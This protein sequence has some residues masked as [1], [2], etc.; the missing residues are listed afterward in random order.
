MLLNYSVYSQS[1]KTAI[2]KIRT[3]D[4]GKLRKLWNGIKSGNTPG[5]ASGKALEYLF[6]RAFDLEK[7]EVVYPYCNNLLHSQEQFDGFIF[8][9][10]LGSGFIVEC[11][12]WKSPVAFDELSKLHGRL[13]YR[14]PSTYG[15]F[16][17]KSGFTLSAMELMYMLNPHKILLWTFND[18]DECFKHHK[19][20]KALKYKYHYAMMTANNNISVID[21][22]NI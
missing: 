13:L 21:G 6:V 8:V 5:W 15:I 4:W 18:I 3:Y 1:E 2:N 9:S 20:I 22:L 12:D 14:S 11:K 17:S 19:F 7:A 10:D 16:V